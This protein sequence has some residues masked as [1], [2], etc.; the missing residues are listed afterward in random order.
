MSGEDR[1]RD[2]IAAVKN[3]LHLTLKKIGIATNRSDPSICLM[4]KGKLKISEEWVESFCQAYHVDKDWL[5]H[6]EGSPVYLGELTSVDLRDSSEAGKRMKQIRESLCMTQTKMAKIVGI[7][8]PMYSRIENGLGG[9]TS[10]NAKNVED[11]LGVGADWILYGDEEKKNYP[12]SRSMIT[13][14][15]EHEELRKEIWARMKEI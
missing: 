3:D 4:L 7:S 2:N 12:I 13:Y 1:I 15:W 5:L 14:L 11:V 6:G 10:E 9:L 8:S